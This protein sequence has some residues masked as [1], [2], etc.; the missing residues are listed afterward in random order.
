MP[1]KSTHQKCQKKKSK[2]QNIPIKQTGLMGPHPSLKSSYLHAHTQKVQC[3]LLIVDTSWVALK[4][5]AIL[6]LLRGKIRIGTCQKC[7]F[8][9]RR[10]GRKVAEH[11]PFWRWPLWPNK[12]I[13]MT[14]FGVTKNVLKN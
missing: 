13:V 3:R 11:L 4:T 12:D 10:H 1:E 2:K 9:S 7:Q 6:A 14:I 8:G 5:G